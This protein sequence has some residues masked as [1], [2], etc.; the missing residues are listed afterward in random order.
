MPASDTTKPIA[1][2]HVKGSLNT[3]QAHNMVTGGLMYKT[4]VTRAG[5]D[6][7]SAR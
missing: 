3:A 1:I 4:A 5:D 6:F 2:A 7:C